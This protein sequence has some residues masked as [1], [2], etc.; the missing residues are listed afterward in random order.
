MRGQCACV[1]HVTVIILL[2]QKINK[3]GEKDKSVC[4]KYFF[5]QSIQ[6]APAENPTTKCEYG[7]EKN[8][9]YRNTTLHTLTHTNQC[10]A[11]HSVGHLT[12]YECFATVG[13][14]REVSLV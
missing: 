9:N 12:N 14:F 3:W 7:Y 13:L 8:T 1:G 2:H 11:F 4:F 6:E 10:I 5:F